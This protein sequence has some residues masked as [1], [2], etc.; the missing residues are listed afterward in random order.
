MTRNIERLTKNQKAG[1]NRI[2]RAL[3]SGYAIENRRG[4]IRLVE[5]AGYVIERKGS[6]T[7]H[8][9]SPNGGKITIENG[10]IP[11]T[12]PSGKP[13]N[14]VYTNVLRGLLT[15]AQERYPGVLD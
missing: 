12:I 10:G 11:L 9:Y 7:K 2:S 14:R 3:I 5:G 15:D 8:V 13:S 6:R 1:I 4:L